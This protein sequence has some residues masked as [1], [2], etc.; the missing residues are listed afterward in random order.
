MCSV[1]GF[2]CFNN[3]GGPTGPNDMYVTDA[4]RAHFT[5]ISRGSVMMSFVDTHGTQCAPPPGLEVI[6]EGAQVP[7]TREEASGQ[8]FKLFGMTPSYDIVMNGDVM[9]SLRRETTI[10]ILAT[11]AALEIQAAAEREIQAR[12]Q[13][14]RMKGM[15][16]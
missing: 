1:G 2:V 5:P 16:V 7:P 10:H 14:R 9:F 4:I 8:S 13:A 6:S 15:G 12:R 11:P 3:E